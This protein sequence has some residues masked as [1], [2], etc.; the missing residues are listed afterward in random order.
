MMNPYQAR[1]NALPAAMVASR[2]ARVG[3]HFDPTASFEGR[4]AAAFRSQYA[5]RTFNP[6]A[7][8]P[9]TRMRQAWGWEAAGRAGQSEQ[10]TTLQVSGLRGHGIASVGRASGSVARTAYVQPPVFNVGGLRGAFQDA[11][12]SGAPTDCSALDKETKMALV[13]YLAA[14][15]DA[16]LEDSIDAVMD[17]VAENFGAAETMCMWG[18]IQSA[19][20]AGDT[21][22]SKA[23]GAANLPRGGT[24]ILAFLLCAGSI[25]AW[26]LTPEEF[27]D[28]RD[29]GKRMEE[30]GW[31]GEGWRTKWWLLSGATP[32]YKNPLYYAGAAAAYL[33]Y[34]YY[35]KRG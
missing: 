15:A 30:R 8:N 13:G 19:W 14:K 6:E 32:W 20:G 1:A 22:G 2:A 31:W 17:G 23:C 5:R 10:S 12:A 29:A 16:G 3:Q 26:G 27:Q 35:R 11:K 18:T 25:D 33:G 24:A 28:A 9:V 34:R 21:P 4:A 7:A